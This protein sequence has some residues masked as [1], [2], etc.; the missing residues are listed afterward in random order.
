M[1]VYFGD[2]GKS[3]LGGREAVRQDQSQDLQLKRETNATARDTNSLIAQYAANADTPEKWAQAMGDLQRAGVN[4]ASQF[5]NRFDLRDTIIQR[6][7]SAAD[8]M[9]S[10]T[11]GEF[12]GSLGNG[13]FGAGTL[14]SLPLGTQQGATLDPTYLAS[15][16]PRGAA[17]P[18]GGIPSRPNTDAPKV[19]FVPGPSLSDNIAALRPAMAS[20]GFAAALG[21][22][23]MPAPLPGPMNRLPTPSAP[24]A[25]MAGASGTNA[26][27]GG[28]GMDVLGDAKLPPSLI[29]AESGGRQFGR[30][31]QPLT[32]PAGAIGVA[33]V[34]PSTAPEA[35]QLAGV[36][37]DENRYRN[38]PAYNEQ[39]GAAYYDAQMRKYG[40]PALAAAAY[41]AGPGAVDDWLAGRR[42]SLPAETVAYVRRVTG[43]DLGASAA[44]GSVR[45]G[46]RD[47]QAPVPNG[48]PL[49]ALQILARNPTYA[50]TAIDAAIGQYGRKP[51]EGVVINGRLVN[52][53]TGQVMADLSNTTSM[54]PPDQAQALGFAP[55]TVVQRKSDGT[56]DVIQSPEKPIEINNRLVNPTNGQVVADFSNGGTVV[57]NDEQARSLGFQPGAVVQ[58]KADGTLDVLQKAPDLGGQNFDDQAKLRQEYIKQSQDYMTV[59]DAYGRLQASSNDETGAS[60]IAMVYSFMKMLDPGSVVREGEFATAQN[61]GGIPD[62]VIAVY[63]GLLSGQRLS[64]QIR[65]NFLQQ[66]GRQFAAATQRQQ[67]VQ[68]QYG[69]LATQYGMDPPKIAID[70]SAGLGA[71]GSRTTAPGQQIPSAAPQAPQSQIPTVSTP[72][73]AAKLPPGT[74]FR[75]PDGQERIRK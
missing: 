51:T 60:D 46:T 4:D 37:F 14:S 21:G 2:W 39:L 24:S 16:P 58:R 19:N 61:S 8:Q 29:M 68:Q 31:G 20:P 48:V 5:A 6:A 15:L 59:R 25:P 56:F 70:L 69:N 66:G 54:L 38:D 13:S 27:A 22:N 34:M 32:S 49:S 18:V 63:N 12:L 43:R 30:N 50:G 26:M 55:G 3:F 62:Q 53:V 47:I 44:T 45:P 36:P 33:Q 74:R 7:Y 17:P 64:P 73:E 42:A 23:G 35:A 41:N 75:T 72:E 9:N 57:L 67:A 52:P 28:A 71:P 10:R 11:A 40:D 1:A 65:Q